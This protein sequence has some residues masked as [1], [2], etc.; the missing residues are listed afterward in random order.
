MDE[1]KPSFSTLN[2]FRVHGGARDLFGSALERLHDE[3]NV[4]ADLPGS[5][6]DVSTDTESDS[7]DDAFLGHHNQLI[8]IINRRLQIIDRRRLNQN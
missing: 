6:S 8:Q 5:A 1:D 7:D 3:M 2:G 4:P